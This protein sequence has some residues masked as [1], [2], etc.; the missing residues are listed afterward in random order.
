[1]TRTQ[2]PWRFF[3]FFFCATEDR[4]PNNIIN[5]RRKKAISISDRL[6]PAQATHKKTKKKKGS[7]HHF[8]HSRPRVGYINTYTYTHTHQTLVSSRN[9][10]LYR[11]T[12]Y[13][14]P[15]TL[16]LFTNITLSLLAHP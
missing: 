14:V 7:H 9:P 8:D 2:L 11:E 13:V 15:F 12:M 6:H 3:L 1:M 4:Q 5:K 10:L 16:V